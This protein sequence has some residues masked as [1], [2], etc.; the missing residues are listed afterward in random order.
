MAP[1]IVN[2]PAPVQLNYN[3]QCKKC[4]GIIKNGSKL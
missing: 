1:T 3:V 2:K 4:S